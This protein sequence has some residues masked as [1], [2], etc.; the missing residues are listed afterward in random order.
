MQQG[1]WEPRVPPRASLRGHLTSA[2]TH[3]TGRF[4]FPP[5]PSFRGSPQQEISGNA[6]EDQEQTHFRRCQ[7]SNCWCYPSGSKL[8]RTISLWQLG[9][10]S[11]SLGLYNPISWMRKWKLKASWLSSLGVNPGHPESSHGHS[12]VPQDPFQQRSTE[13]LF[14]FRENPKSNH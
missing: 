11:V 10:E 14:T 1:L 2:T 7:M 6:A 12:A 4:S 5:S 8:F 9:N 13:S 3:L